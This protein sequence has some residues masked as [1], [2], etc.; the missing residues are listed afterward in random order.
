PAC[1]ISSP[2]PPPALP[3]FPPR[4][5][6]DLKS[7]PSCKGA[8]PRRRHAHC[9]PDLQISIATGKAVSIRIVGLVKHCQGRL[10]PASCRLPAYYLDRKSTRLN[11]SH[12]KISY[13]VFCL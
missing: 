2:S 10:C 1:S 9:L 8:S 6:S 11:S 3:A 5:S 12:V 13:A 7:F 4:R